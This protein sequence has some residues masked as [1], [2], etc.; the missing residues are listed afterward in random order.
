MRMVAER[1]HTGPKALCI[2]LARDPGEQ[3][4]LFRREKRIARELTELLLR[5]REGPP[6]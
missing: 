6:E 1:R 5:R 2:Y 4:N 3:D